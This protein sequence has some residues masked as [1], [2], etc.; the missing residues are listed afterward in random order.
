MR[1]WGPAEAF[2]IWSSGQEPVEQET[3]QKD[4]PGVVVSMGDPQTLVLSI[5]LKVS[6]SSIATSG[7]RGEMTEVE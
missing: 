5:F 6:I 1:Q 7:E 2:G 3:R 4:G